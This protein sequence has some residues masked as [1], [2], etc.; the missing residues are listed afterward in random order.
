MVIIRVFI[1]AVS[2]SVITSACSS[3]R[4][5]TLKDA[6]WFGAG[7]FVQYAGHELSH[8]AVAKAQGIDCKFTGP[9]TQH[10]SQPVGRSVKMAGHAFN[11]LADEVA[12]IFYNGD[13]PFIEGVLAAGAIEGMKTSEKDFSGTWS[14]Q[15]TWKDLTRAHAALVAKRALELKYK[16]EPSTRKGRDPVI[17]PISV[18]DKMGVGIT[19]RW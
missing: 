11:A 2:V 12:L 16:S 5:V 9:F 4:K 18:N 15:E 8:Y 6:A 1:L 14:G 3:I 7:V 19:W 17:A 13:S 10:Y